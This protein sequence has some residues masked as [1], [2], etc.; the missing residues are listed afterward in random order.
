MNRRR[1]INLAGAAAL[2]GAG[3][4]EFFPASARTAAWP[5]RWNDLARRLKGPLLRPGDFGFGAS[6]LPN[7]LRYAS[8][9]PAAVA[10]CEDAHDVSAAIAWAR[11]YEIPFVARSG[12]HSYAGY[13][14]TTGLT[15]DLGRMRA[16]GYDP[17]SG[18]ATV[19]GGAHNADVFAALRPVERAITHGRCHGVGIA[20][21]AL[22]GG[23]GFNDR[24]YGVTCDHLLETTIVTAD[25][26][27]RT[28]SASEE[29]DLYWACR[30]GGGGNF[31]IHTSFRFRTFPVDRLTVFDLVWT[32]RIDDAFPALLRA[33]DAAPSALG[34]KLS[35]VAPSAAQRSAGIGL[36]IELIGQLRGT[37]AELA[38]ILGPVYRIAR[39]NGQVRRLR[40]WDGQD[41]LSEAG[42]PEF[43]HE[44]SRFFNGPI[45]DRAIGI[46]L[47]AMRQAPNLSQSASFKLFQTG[48]AMNALAS[49]ANAFVHR[50]SR[51]LSSIALVW[52]R[53]D[54]DAAVQR[55]LAWQQTSYEAYVPLAGGGAYQNFID[56]AL[57]D[58]KQAYYGTNLSR[59]EQ[60]KARFDPDRVFRFAEAV[61][62]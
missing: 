2:A 45:S 23:V 40:Y 32:Q 1:F 58:W 17:A 18:V 36:S 49:D 31:G 34:S 13:S 4:L 39:P 38:E 21:L 15:I 5:Q 50:E 25:G 28:V 51:W 53:I 61:T 30:G 47:A 11:E 44:S 6:A 3:G 46:I 48:G 7:N 55:A 24:S 20:G 12:G 35:I 57:R 22:G 37:P 60:V 59:L 29:P 33:L 52:G 27:I 56:P 19:G 10:F 43:F 9:R 42:T 62:A 26:K 54:S 41:V 14:T 16:V 8:V